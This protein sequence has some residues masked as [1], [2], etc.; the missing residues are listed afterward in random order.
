[1]LPKGDQ[2]TTDKGGKGRD[3]GWNP[4][5][6]KKH[7]AKTKPTARKGFMREG[8]TQDTSKLNT[9]RWAES[10]PGANFGRHFG[11]PLA[12][13]WHPFHDLFRRSIS[14]A[15]GNSSAP[16]P[17]EDNLHAK[18]YKKFDARV[19]AGVFFAIFCLKI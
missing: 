12:P 13:F 10:G 14:V 5:R 4:P 6:K 16:G 1:M 3:P 8:N 7:I 15:K 17:R 11:H 9:L 2:N 19:N 18:I